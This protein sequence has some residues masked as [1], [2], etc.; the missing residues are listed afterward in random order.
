MLRTLSVPLLDWREACG[1]REE[2]AS[3]VMRALDTAHE[4]LPPRAT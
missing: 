3:K 2:R 1:I 4:E